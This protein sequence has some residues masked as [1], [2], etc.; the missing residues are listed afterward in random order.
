MKA[1]WCGFGVEAYQK[2][3]DA[4]I[5][6]AV[7]KVGAVDMAGIEAMRNTAG[8]QVIKEAVAGVQQRWAQALV[9]RRD[10]RS[11]ALAD[12]LLGSA[13][14]P[15]DTAAQASAR[16]QALARTSSDPMVTALALMRPCASR[17]CVNVEASQWSRLEPANVQGWLALL[18]GPMNKPQNQASYV[19][20]RVAMEGRYSRSYQQEMLAMLWSLPQTETPGLQREA[21][22]AAFEGISALWLVQSMRPLVEA[23]RAAGA[24]HDTLSRC[25]AVAQVL[26]SDGTEF[27]RRM[28]LALMRFVVAAEP[29]RRPL[30]EPRARELEAVAQWQQDA[31]LRTLNRFFPDGEHPLP[32]CEGHAISRQIQREAAARNDWERSRAEMR[33]AGVDEAALAA[34]WR[35]REGRS[36]LD[37]PIRAPAPAASTAG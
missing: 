16:L 33:G 12:Y 13:E 34:A 3:T 19:M 28:A 6:S 27:D 8:A 9:Q 26:W 31:G 20:D 25:E 35:L 5:E 21:E 30:W 32:H 37:S 15:A 4:V 22:I 23:C 11:L 10:P 24:G 7:A 2:Q 36:A 14:Q 1:D 18:Q 29:G 17:G